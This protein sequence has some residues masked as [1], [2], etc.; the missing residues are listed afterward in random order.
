[1]LLSEFRV[2]E[3]PEGNTRRHATCFFK[4]P[5]RQ[6]Q[7]DGRSL[8]RVYPSRRHVPISTQAYV[9]KISNHRVRHRPTPCNWTKSWGPLMRP[10]PPLLCSQP[11]HA[12]IGTHPHNGGR[13]LYAPPTLTQRWHRA[14]PWGTSPQPVAPRSI[15]GAPRKSPAA[16]APIARGWQAGRRIPKTS[17]AI[18]FLHTILTRHEGGPPGKALGLFVDQHLQH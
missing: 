15:R 16:R 3:G 6:R 14:P 4:C 17:A 11:K 7:H 8:K 1:V 13:R 5:R 12:R 10:L 18:Q 2:C 9:Q